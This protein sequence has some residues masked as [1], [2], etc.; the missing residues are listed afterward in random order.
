MAIDGTVGEEEFDIV[1]LGL[2][3]TLELGTLVFQVLALIDTVISKNLGDVADGGQEAGGRNEATY[4]IRN[5]VDIAVEGRSNRGIG[6]V[7]L[8]TLELGLGLLDLHAGDLLLGICLVETDF[9]DNVLCHHAADALRFVL[10]HLVAGLGLLEVG[11]SLLHLLG[12]LLGAE[13]EERL[14]LETFCPS[15]TRI[16]WTKPSTFGLDFDNLD[17]LDIGDIRLRDINRCR[18][19][20]RDR[21]RCGTED[22]GTLRLVARLEQSCTHEEDC[23]HL[24]CIY[25]HIE[26][27][28]KLL[29]AF[30]ENE[31]CVWGRIP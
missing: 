5:A 20:H 9:G 21:R 14:A 23:K 16:C 25:L 11:L 26:K 8:S 4:L 17:S 12:I 31:N 13:A 19:Q 30:N 24:E 29:F 18:L 28:N 6:I 22:G 2:L 1:H 15:S 10:G 27:E 7:R 3:L